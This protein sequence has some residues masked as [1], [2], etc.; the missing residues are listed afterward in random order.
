MHEKE[1]RRKK[2]DCINQKE[3]KN[4]IMQLG[5][6][7]GRRQGGQLQSKMFSGYTYQRDHRPVL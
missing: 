7:R 5:N 4:R 1:R 6:V 2:E 3:K